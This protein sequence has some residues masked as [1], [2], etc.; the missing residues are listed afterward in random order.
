M[1]SDV[2]V[3]V[4]AWRCAATIGRSLESLAAQAGGPAPH[5]IVAVNDG[6]P[7]SVAAAEAHRGALEARGM[8]FDVIS[9]PPGRRAAFAGAEAIAAPGGARLYL[10]QDARLS[11]GALAALARAADGGEARM[12]A[13]ALRFTRSPSFAVRAFLRAWLSLPYVQ[14]S[15]VVAGAFAVSAAGRARWTALPP[16]A[17]DDKFV[18]MCFAPAERSY[19]ADEH[20]EVIAPASFGELV[21]RRAGYMRGNRELARHFM[22]TPAVDSRRLAGWPRLLL[23]PID[24]AVLMATVAAAT[25][26]SWRRRPARA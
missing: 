18:R 15:P 4:P 24:L 5:V 25:L 2:T 9:T 3:I 21:R 16:L 20:Y 10:D 7:A 12:I 19:L 17:S 23:R 26:L 11:P 1:R 6:D 13:L 22:A 8:R 14:A